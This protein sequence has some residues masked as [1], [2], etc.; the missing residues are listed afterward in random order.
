M[1]RLYKL[2]KSYKLCKDYTRCAK[3]ASCAKTIQVVQKIQIMQRQNS[4]C[5]KAASYAKTVHAVQKLQVMQRLAV[6]RSHSGYLKAE[7]RLYTLYKK[8]E[9]YKGYSQCEDHLGVSESRG[10]RRPRWQ[11]MDHFR[12]NRDKRIVSSMPLTT[13]VCSA[14]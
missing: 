7:G 8:Y 11:A 6:R 12:N 13:V 3:A 4:R 9:L 2:C 1:Q 10:K 14:L 5:A